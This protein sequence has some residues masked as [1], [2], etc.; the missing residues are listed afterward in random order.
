MSH[1]FSN[2]AD[3]KEVS[4]RSSR[5]RADRPQHRARCESG[6]S[7]L[8]GKRPFEPDVARDGATFPAA[9]EAPDLRGTTL[10]EVATGLIDPK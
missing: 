7:R 6:K 5:R 3:F 9:M 10:V 4:I 8:P 1:I 2:I